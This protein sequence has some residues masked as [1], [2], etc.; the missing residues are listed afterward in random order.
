MFFQKLRRFKPDFAI[1]D[2]NIVV[3]SHI[4]AFSRNM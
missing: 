1:F 4:I 2:L 3:L